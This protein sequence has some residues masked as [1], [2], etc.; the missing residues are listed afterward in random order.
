MGIVFFETSGN[1][2]Q[3]VD[4]KQ[5]ETL[6]QV[7]LGAGIAGIEAACGGNCSC[8]TC[9]VVIDPAWADKVPP[10]SDDEHDLLDGVAAERQS[11]SRLSCQIKLTAELD[12]VV[13]SVPEI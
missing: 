12:Q 7:A 6:M 1:A 13:V 4:F 2:P 8:A 9:H 11:N 3:S 5:G 10:V